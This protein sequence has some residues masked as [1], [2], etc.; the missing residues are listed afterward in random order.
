MLNRVEPAAVIVRR[1]EEE[2]EARLRAVAKKV[3]PRGDT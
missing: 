1:I 2:A 3:D